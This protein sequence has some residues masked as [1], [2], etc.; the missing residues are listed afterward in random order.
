MPGTPTVTRFL[1]AAVVALAMAG[2]VAAP[3]GAATAGI[4]PP[5][6]PA[7]D[8][9]AKGR[10]PALTVQGLD[11]CRAKEGVGP[12]TLPSNWT[13]L[14]GPEQMLVVI[15]LERVNRGLAP[16]V[17]L[18]PTL[19]RLAAAGARARNDPRFPAAGYQSAGSI[20]FGGDS[21]IAADYGWMYDDG[22]KGLDL[23][24]D[25]PA[26]GHSSS[27]WLHRD[28]ILLSGAGRALVGG[29]GSVRGSY[30][31]E[32]LSGYSRA[33][34]TFTWAHELRYFTSKPGV[35]RQHPPSAQ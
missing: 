32:I 19:D 27:C 7:A 26:A 5:A 28:I 17:G 9:D 1:A 18:N 34:L 21:T 11:R 12:L 33:G 24:E 30:A 8:C 31:F 22:P 35:E 2:F 10:D 3:A 25:C 16:V 20:W 6:N 13:M 15:D 23:N 29:G 4:L 14:S